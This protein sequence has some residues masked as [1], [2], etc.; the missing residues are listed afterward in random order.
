MRRRMGVVMIMI[1][2]FILSASDGLP[3]VFSAALPQYILEMFARHVTAAISSPL[4]SDAPKLS[5][6]RERV[7]LRSGPSG[8]SRRLLELHLPWP[9]PPLF[10]FEPLSSSLPQFPARFKTETRKEFRKAYTSYLSCLPQNKTRPYIFT[11]S[12]P[13]RT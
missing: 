5:V 3:L 13:C 6:L 12:T 9:W 8:R 11:F 1:T 7:V 10:A 4:S 2:V